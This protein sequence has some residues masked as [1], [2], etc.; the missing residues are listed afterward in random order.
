MIEFTPE[1]T[2]EIT[3]YERAY[4]PAG[5]GTSDNAAPVEVLTPAQI[6]KLTPEFDQPDK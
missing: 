5:T 4:G 2:R 1:E 6:R 3:A